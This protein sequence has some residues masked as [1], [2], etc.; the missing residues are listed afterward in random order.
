MSSYKSP[1]SMAIMHN[2]YANM[3]KYMTHCA[4]HNPILNVNKLSLLRQQGFSNSNIPQLVI[5]RPIIENINIIYAR[6]KYFFVKIHAV[7]NTN[8]IIENSTI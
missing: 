4:K 2:E 5:D 7:L 1:P 3:Y 8:V 6:R